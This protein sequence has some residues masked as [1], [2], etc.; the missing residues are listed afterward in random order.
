MPKNLFGGGG[1]SINPQ[2]ILK[3]FNFGGLSGGFNGNTFNVRASPERQ[4]LVDRLSALFGEQAGV[5]GSEIIPRFGDA[6]SNQINTIN[7]E[8]LPRVAPGFGELTR[9]RGDVFES[10]LQR[11]EDRRRSAAGDLRE[12][13]SR[14]RLSG[15]SFASDAQSR[16]DAEF[17]RTE[18]ELSAAMAE[19]NAMSFLQE[20]EATV[21]LINQRFQ[22]EV[23]AVDTLAQNINTMFNLQRQQSGVQL[24]E[25]DK[26]MQVASGLF[27]QL[28]SE[29][30]ASAR[31]QQQLAAQSAGG[32][33]QLLG[34][35]LAAFTG[36][37]SLGLS[38]MFGGLFGGGAAAAGATPFL[39][40]AAM[41]SPANFGGLM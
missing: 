17:Q 8:L 30:G 22:T 10:A 19:A 11:L 28:T 9:A 27:Q 35:G 40:G 6:F 16:Q 13:L 37:G 5:I 15:S 41:G 24:E 34:L 3:P 14:R 2:Q 21:G 31:L 7:D 20:F 18:D 39:S 12:N 1:G 26:Q 32:F 25:L 23:M 29:L 38:G 36:G 33:G 4:A